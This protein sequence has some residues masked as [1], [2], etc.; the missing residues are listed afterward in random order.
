MVSACVAAIAA[1]DPATSLD[2]EYAELVPLSTRSLLLDITLIPDGGFIAVGERGHVVH[3]MDGQEWQQSEVV[4]TRSTLTTIA[5]SHGR[6]WAAGHDSVILTSSDNGKTW[7]RQFF[8]PDRQQ[9]IMDLHFFDAD[10]GMAIGAYGLALFTSDGG[11][12]WQDQLVNEEEWHNN[13][14]LAVNENEIMVAGE[15]GYSYRSRDGG[16]SWETLNMPY[17][18]SMFGVV[19]GSDGCI[20]EFG[21]RG[22]VQE[23]CN[24]GD[25]WEE[26]ETGTESSIAGAVTVDGDTVMVGNSGLVL[27]REGGGSFTVH[28]HSS[29]VDF[30]AVVYVGNGRFLLSGEDGIHQFPEIWQA[31]Q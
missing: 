17:P 27:T 31:E 15:A 21:L 10:R 2:V 23:T 8:D 3:S 22:H 29:G 7:T 6:L 4:P 13:A 30:A 16:N 26:I 25:S 9:P 18:G 28:Q 20:T 14:I 24:F 11:A 19:A 1:D 12:S 5:Q